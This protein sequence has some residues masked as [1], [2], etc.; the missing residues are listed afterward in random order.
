MKNVASAWTQRWEAVARN[1]SARGAGAFARAPRSTPLGSAASQGVGGIF[2]SRAACK[3]QHPCKTSG[4]AAV[5]GLR[6][7]SI[8]KKIIGHGMR[9]IVAGVA[10]GKHV[11]RPGGTLSLLQKQARQHSSGVFLHPL[12]EQGGNLLAE[13]GGMRQTRQ[14][15][16]L[17]GVPGSREQELPRWLGRTGGHRPPIGDAANISR[18]V[19]HVKNTYR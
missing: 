17:Q 2:S 6:G 14:F 4:R 11:R 1:G 16:A 18:R 15:K 13:I 19:R 7:G 9:A 3:L 5:Y 8:R 10:F 12:I